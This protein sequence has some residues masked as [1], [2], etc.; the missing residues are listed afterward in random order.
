VIREL[1]ETVPIEPAKTPVATG[2]PRDIGAGLSGQ[3]ERGAAS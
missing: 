1:L 3:R 2:A